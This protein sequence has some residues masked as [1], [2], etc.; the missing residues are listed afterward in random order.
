M[1]P[2][3]TQL[4]LGR[5]VIGVLSWLMPNLINRIF[6]INPKANPNAAFATRLFGSRD[7]VLGVA[8]MQMTGP[9]RR[10][11]WQLGIAVDAADAVAAGLA[12]RNG[13]LPKP[14]ALAAAGI[15]ISAVGLG[16]VA[17]QAE[18]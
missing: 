2:P 5:I 13:S 6:G 12:A 18:E 10:L 9:S 4:P 14:M 17:L 8:Q 3:A 7:A 1:P 15:A 16:V 11:A